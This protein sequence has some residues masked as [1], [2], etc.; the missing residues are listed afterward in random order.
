[1]FQFLLCNLFILIRHF[2]IFNNYEQ[3]NHFMHRKIIKNKSLNIP[4]FFFHYVSLCSFFRDGEKSERYKA[5]YIY[6]WHRTTILFNIV[7]ALPS[8]RKN[9]RDN[10]R[11]SW[12]QY[13]MITLEDEKLAN[14]IEINL[15]SRRRYLCH[16]SKSAFYSLLKQR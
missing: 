4:R 15:R 2:C 8:T 7:L 11:V 9:L 1:M 3:R 14:L 13:N 10:R 5:H 6:P 12:T 16:L